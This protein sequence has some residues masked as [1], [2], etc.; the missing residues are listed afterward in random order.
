MG[1]RRGILWK[2]KITCLSNSSSYH[3]RSTLYCYDRCY[4]AV[5]EKNRWTQNEHRGNKPTISSFIYLS[6]SIYLSIYLSISFSIS[7]SLHWLTLLMIIQFEE[8]GLDTKVHNEEAFEENPLVQQFMDN[9]SQGRKFS[10]R[11]FNSN[12]L[13]MSNR[14]NQSNNNNNNKEACDHPDHDAEKA[15]P[16]SKKPQED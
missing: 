11:S 12:D 7:V 2:T 16:S 5:L 1:S 8:D 15:S 3:C 10:F 6:I 14:K 9:W 13:P 4:F